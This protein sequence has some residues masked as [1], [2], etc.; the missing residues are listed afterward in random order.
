MN[1]FWNFS[2]V[3]DTEAELMLYGPI[4]S[5]R[6][7]WSGDADMMVVQGDFIKELKANDG[8]NITLKINSPG[9]DVFAATAIRSNL[10]QHNGKVIGIIE[11]LA[12]SAA[13]IPLSGCEIVR[14]FSNAEV[15]IHDPMVGMMGYYNGDELDKVKNAWASIKESILNSYVTKSKVDRKEL[16]KMMKNETWMTADE[17]KEKGFVDEIIDEEALNSAITN[18]GRYL[19]INSIVH[20]LSK[21]KTRPI[22]FSQFI[23]IPSAPQALEAPAPVAN[24]INKQ[25]VNKEME[26]KNTE[27]LKKAY[28]ELVDQIETAAAA[29]AVNAE[30]T[31]IQDIE[32][33]AKNVDPKLVDKAKFT[34][35]IDAKELAFQAMQLDSNKGNSYLAKLTVDSKD[36]GAAK[37]VATPIEQKTEEEKIEATNKAVDTIASGG[38][39]RRTR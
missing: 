23:P 24:I 18:D 19:F 3:S 29:S 37:V 28:P 17:A 16:S 38:D 35:P 26:I 13:T 12:A 20:D 14:A 22:G 21:F 30:R 32:K 7:W 9:G 6:P 34:E 15:M 36:S 8:K 5:E 10:K 1:K 33:I 25:E 2:N 27:E 4:M 39:K 11:G 31:R